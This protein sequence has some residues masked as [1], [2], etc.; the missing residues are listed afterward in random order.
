MLVKILLS[1]IAIILFSGCA[2]DPEPKPEIKI[3]EKKVYIK[4]K[5]RD[6]VTLPKIEIYV[7]KDISDYNATHKLVNDAQLQ[8]ASKISIKRAENLLFY[9]NQNKGIR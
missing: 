2:S 8:H 1:F 5:E 3:V 4:S 7:I 9:E 6:L